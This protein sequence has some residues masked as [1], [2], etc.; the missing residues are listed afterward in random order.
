MK[1]KKLRKEL[2]DTIDDTVNLIRLVNRNSDYIC[3]LGRELL[4]ELSLIPGW[5]IMLSCDPSDFDSSNCIV[6]YDASSQFISFKRF[7]ETYL[8]IRLDMELDKQVRQAKELL[9]GCENSR[10]VLSNLEMP[11]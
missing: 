8:N 7:G 11:F 9:Y 4:E 6:D 5:Q 3:R 2:I 10:N 1:E